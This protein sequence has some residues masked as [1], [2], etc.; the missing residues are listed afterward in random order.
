MSGTPIEMSKVKQVI[1]MYESGVPKKDIARRL[2]I[3]KNTVKEY[4]KKAVVRNLLEK[5]GPLTTSGR[6]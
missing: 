6:F 4:I 1:R 2:G 5:T 3:S